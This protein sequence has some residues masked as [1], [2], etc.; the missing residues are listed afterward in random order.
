MAATVPADVSKALAIGG[1]P[2]V[3]LSPEEKQAWISSMTSNRNG[4][5]YATRCPAAADAYGMSIRPVGLGAWMIDHD[6]RSVPSP[7][8]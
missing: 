8:L 5:G 4:L 1:P 7:F 2:P 6:I 3:G